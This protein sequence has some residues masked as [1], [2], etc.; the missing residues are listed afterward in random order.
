MYSLS[1]VVAWS[2]STTDWRSIALGF[3]EFVKIRKSLET[4][5][6]FCTHYNYYI[7]ILNISRQ[8]N[9]FVC[10]C[11]QLHRMQEKVYHQHLHHHLLR[12]NLFTGTISD[13][14]NAK[15]NMVQ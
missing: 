7:L 2:C 8:F 13:R 11:G 1:G 5:S 15:I 14:A 4:G 3:A 10:K 6:H 9:N 12:I